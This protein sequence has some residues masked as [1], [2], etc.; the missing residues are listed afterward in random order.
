MHNEKSNH[1]TPE[2]LGIERRLYN[3]NEAA[4]ILRITREHLHRLVKG[5]KIGF[6]KSGNRSIKFSAEN[7][8]QYFTAIPREEKDD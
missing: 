2:Q 8:T 7:L 1:P 4:E 6:L 5:R 3:Y